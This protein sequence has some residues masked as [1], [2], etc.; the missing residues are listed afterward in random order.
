MP[1]M[2]P[3][4]ALERAAA[5]LDKEHVVGLRVRCV[6]GEFRVDDQLVPDEARVASGTL[7]GLAGGR[8]C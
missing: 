8:R 6:G 5:D 1:A 7:A 4:A 2:D 3:H